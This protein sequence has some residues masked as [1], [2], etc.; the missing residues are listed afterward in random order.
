VHTC[1]PVALTSSSVHSAPSSGKI[2]LAA[3]EDHRLDVEPEL[4]D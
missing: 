2:V 1:T 4:V 3:A